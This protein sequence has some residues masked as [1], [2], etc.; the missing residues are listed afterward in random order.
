MVGLGVRDAQAAEEVGRRHVDFAHLY[1]VVLQPTLNETGA[2]RVASLLDV[3][4][5]R[6]AI[7]GT[8]IHVGLHHEFAADCVPDLLWDSRHR[9]RLDFGAQRRVAAEVPEQSI[10]LAI[11]ERLAAIVSLPALL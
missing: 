5:L 8:S 11:P 4:G 10:E 9:A 6:L 1:R 7:G 2:L 3:S